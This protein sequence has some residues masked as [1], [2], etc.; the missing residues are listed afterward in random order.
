[1]L[2]GFGTD[3]G[4][5]VG[6][7][8]G[9]LG[10]AGAGAGVGGLGGAGVGALLAALQHKPIGAGAQ[11]GAQLGAMLGGSA[12]GLGGAG[13]GLVKGLSAGNRIT[14]RALTNMG[15]P[16]RLAHE[17]EE[18]RAQLSAADQHVQEAVERFK[19]QLPGLAAQMGVQGALTSSLVGAGLGGAEAPQGHG[20]EGALRGGVAGTGTALGALG[21]AGLGAYAGHELGGGSIPGMIAGGLGGA[22]LGALAGHFGSNALMGRPSWE[23]DKEKHA[24]VRVPPPVAPLGKRVPATDSEPVALQAGWPQPPRRGAYAP[25]ST[26]QLGGH[27]TLQRGDSFSALRGARPLK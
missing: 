27:T 25:E 16:Y 20:G 3:V 12:G 22:G 10:G 14:D 26:A 13:Y 9:G 4:G 24:A 18:K 11:G 21:G 2:T 7:V 17:K 1:V 8:L 23:R 6:T 15:V 19:N 5:S